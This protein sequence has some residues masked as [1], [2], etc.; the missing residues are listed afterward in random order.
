MNLTVFEGKE[1]KVLAFDEGETI[2]EVLQKNGIRS[3]TAP[4]GGK[5]TCKKCAVFVSSE[6]LCGS[7]LACTTAAQDQMTVEIVPEVRISFAD[8]GSDAV[9]EPTPGQSGYAVAC[10]IGTTTVICRLLNL[11]TGEKISGISGSSSQRIFGGDVLSRL[12]AAKDGH[13]NEIHELIIHQVNDNLEEL[14]S[15]A[16]IRKEDIKRMAV[17]GNTIM[18]H[19]FAGIDPSRISTAPFEPVSLFGETVKG[20]EIGLSFEGDV[21]LCPAVAGFIGSDLA[22]G[23]LMSGMHE[24]EGKILLIDLGTNTEVVMGN[25]D[26]IVACAVDGGAVFKASLLEHGMIAAH[27]AIFSIKLEGEELVLGVLGDKEPKGICGSGYIDALGIL[28]REGILDEMGHIVDPDETDSPLAIHIGEEDGRNVF[29]LTED[30]TI[31]LSEADISKFMLAK[32]AIHAAIQ[33]LCKE[34]GTELSEIEKL[35]LGGAFGAFVHRSNAAILG[36]IPKEC[37]G[38]TCKSGNTALDGASSAALSEDA[39]RELLQIQGSVQVIDLP[40]H[41][42][43]NDAF[44][45]GMIIEE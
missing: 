6:Q 30:H 36:I 21:F 13:A 45:D 16:N 38:K 32:A 10:D 11:E 39:R 7:Y 4:C 1:K 15:R 41:P 20:S 35:V 26:K 40:K 5:G 28:F 42:M 14:C 8:R 44:I 37:K 43:F 17:S 24:S 12:E 23:I 31:Y 29:Y 19:F 3:I 22:C 27:G 2:L 9:W 33:I 25:R 18:M 34:T